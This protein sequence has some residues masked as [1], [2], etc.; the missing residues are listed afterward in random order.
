MGPT[1][2]QIFPTL[3][4]FW[5]EELARDAANRRR[6]GREGPRPQ[7]G[8]PQPAARPGVALYKAFGLW[9]KARAWRRQR[10]AARQI[11]GRQRGANRCIGQM[12]RRPCGTG[13]LARPYAPDRRL[14]DG[15]TADNRR[16]PVTGQFE[17]SSLR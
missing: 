1:D 11:S 7:G 8:L 9:L 10:G 17:A 4:Q 5:V 12:A 6:S 14:V 15:A 2:E 3:L 13:Q 16:R